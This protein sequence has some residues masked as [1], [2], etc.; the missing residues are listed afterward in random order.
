MMKGDMLTCIKKGVCQK[1][2]ELAEKKVCSYRNNDMKEE[3]LGD[4]ISNKVSWLI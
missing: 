4:L 2:R 1:I 3:Q